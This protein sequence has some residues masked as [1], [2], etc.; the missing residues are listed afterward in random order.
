MVFDGFGIDVLG[1]FL[2][3]LENN[4]GISFFQGGLKRGKLIFSEFLRNEAVAGDNPL[5]AEAVFRK[6]GNVFYEA[7][8]VFIVADNDNFETGGKASA[9]G[10]A[11]FA[12]SETDDNK[13]NKAENERPNGNGTARKE[14]GFEKELI[15]DED[16]GTEDRSRAG[17]SDFGGVGALI[18]NAAAVE[19]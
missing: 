19:T 2:V 17:A 6:V 1:S 7:L 14:S 10:A 15:S 12:N 4:V 3:G 5:Q 13:S 11:D 16:H 8:G 9:D 18:V